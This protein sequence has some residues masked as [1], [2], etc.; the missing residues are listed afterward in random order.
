MECEGRMSKTPSDKYLHFTVGLLKGSE[1]LG[2]LQDDALKHHMIDNPGQLI[3]LRLSE[4]Y[5]M[6]QRGIVQPVVRVPA[7]GVPLEAESASGPEKK[8][9]VSPTATP[10]PAPFSTIPST[11]MPPITN[12]A[13]FPVVPSAPVIPTTPRPTVPPAAE[14]DPTLSQT[15]PH[16]RALQQHLQQQKKHLQHQD[17]IDVA[18]APNSADQNADDAADYWTVL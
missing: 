18:F 12:T 4:Y 8:A 15:T 14:A 2:A 7:V 9:S 13:Q 10:P 3:A 16:L 6:M 5:E 17:P 1:A 11:P